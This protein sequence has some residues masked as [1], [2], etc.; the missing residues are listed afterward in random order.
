M[1]DEQIVLEVNGLSKCFRI[2][3][4]P[5]DRLKQ[6]LWCGRRCY[7]REF[8]ALRE[9]SFVTQRGEALAIIGRN[10]SGKSTLLQLICGTLT[11]TAGSVI[12]RGRVAALLELGS[13]FNPE[14]S[15]RE[16]VFLNASLL[17]LSTQQTLERLDDILAF[18]DIGEFIDQPVKTYSSG[19][20][21]RL[22][23]AV[24]T[25]A[26]AD[27]LVID[28]ALAVGD[29]VFTQRCMRFI[30]H[31]R[32]TRTLLLVSHDAAS[33]AAL[34]DRALWLHEGSLQQ[35][36]PTPEVM[37]YYV[38]FCQRL[39]GAQQ[40]RAK[41]EPDL[42][43][44]SIEPSMFTAPSS[45]PE[46]P[47]LG[48]GLVHDARQELVNY[49]LLPMEFRCGSFTGGSSSSHADGCCEVRAV[50]F[51]DRRGQ[52]LAFLRGGS[53]CRLRIQ[54]R[55]LQAVRSPIIGFAVLDR[56]GQVLF[57]ENTFG[58]GAHAEMAVAAGDCLE[59]VFEMEWPWLAAGEY[60]VTVAMASG[61][62]VEHVNHCWLNDCVLITST[63]GTRLVSGLFAPPM[64]HID[65]ERHHDG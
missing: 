37:P 26:D 6:S 21:L 36:G 61:G 51:E 28:E 5:R 35:I 19:M 58:N 55:V 17:G 42:S 16:N 41:E 7:Y 57:G 31:C 50:G 64:L 62:R 1:V 29:A 22:A 43:E 63:P 49:E 2:Y 33:V 54:G 39:T 59:A 15:G 23:F 52:P 32:E 20:Q 10:G 12:T 8:W 27:L 34:T 18:A 48:G 14:F 11:A 44:H 30:H 4:S 24:I 46:H 65:L 40:T 47:A 13:G 25:Q 45:S 53:V 38:N 9:L 60:V 56:L 3:D